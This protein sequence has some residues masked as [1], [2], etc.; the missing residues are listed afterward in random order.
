M[1]E[2][3]SG[4]WSGSLH[5]GVTH[6]VT[7]TVLTDKFRVATSLGLPTFTP[8]WLDQIWSRSGCAQ[9]TAEDAVFSCHEA[10]ALLG[11]KICVSQLGRTDREMLRKELRQMQGDSRSR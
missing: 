1:I 11:V 5:S 4:E 7:R 2:A 8:A 9:V 6:L 10:P 3:M